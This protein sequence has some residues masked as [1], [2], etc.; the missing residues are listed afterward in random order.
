MKILLKMIP[1]NIEGTKISPKITP[2]N[3]ERQS[4]LCNPQPNVEP[5][6]LMVHTHATPIQ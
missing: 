2:P 6:I 4:P 3:I 5:T 1:P